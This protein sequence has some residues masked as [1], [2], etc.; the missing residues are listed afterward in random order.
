LFFVLIELPALV[1]ALLIGGALGGAVGGFIFALLMEHVFGTRSGIPSFLGFVA[2][3][4]CFAG[5]IYSGYRKVHRTVGT[6]RSRR[7]QVKPDAVVLLDGGAGAEQ[8]RIARPA[9]RRVK[10]RNTA[11]PEFESNPTNVVIHGGGLSGVANNARVIHQQARMKK[12]IAICYTIQLDHD[13]ESTTLV[14]GLDELT[15]NNVFQDISQDLQLAGA[16]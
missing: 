16:R 11:A 14:D 7:F 3:L 4:V 13:D 5:V 8:R 15:A 2:A 6:R 12:I 1:I 10:M 9:I